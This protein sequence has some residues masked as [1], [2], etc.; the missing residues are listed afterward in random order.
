[1]AWAQMAERR[2]TRGDS[3]LRTEM[4]F[5]GPAKEIGRRTIAGPN[6]RESP[7]APTGAPTRPFS[8]PRQLYEDKVLARPVAVSHHCPTSNRHSARRNSLKRRCGVV[9]AP[10]KGFGAHIEE[11]KRRGI[12][13]SGLAVHSV[14]FAQDKKGGGRARRLQERQQNT[15]RSETIEA[16]FL[17]RRTRSKSSPRREALNLISRSGKSS[18]QG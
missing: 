15:V 5:R 14:S 8:S 11:R 4:G 2:E 16:D 12:F 9:I 10:A 17:T 7:S 3:P 1:V 18:R 13:L 6:P